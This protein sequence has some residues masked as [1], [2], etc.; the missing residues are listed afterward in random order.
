MLLLWRLSIAHRMCNAT[1]QKS[2]IPIQHYLNGASI[3]HLGRLYKMRIQND[4]KREVFIQDNHFCVCIQDT[5]EPAVARFVQSW[6]RQQAIDCFQRSLQP[7]LPW[8]ERQTLPKPVLK[9]RIMANRWGST[10]ASGVIYVNP[11]LIQAPL[12]LIE[13]VIVHELCHLRHLDHSAAFWAFLKQA[14]PDYENRERQ[15]SD[16]D[17]HRLPTK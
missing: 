7:W 16:I 6:Q 14:L 12:S 8:C 9:L 5:S 3:F 17:W 1:P 4:A 13:Y 11:W 2:D 15:F 10:T